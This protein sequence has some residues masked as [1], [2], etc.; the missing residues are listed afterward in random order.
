MRKY[1][2]ENDEPI[3]TEFVTINSQIPEVRSVII[4]KDQIP[5]NLLV[6][7]PPFFIAI[8]NRD[9]EEAKTLAVMEFE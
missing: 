9:E 8:M 3:I 4:P 1:V 2:S 5:P 6:L 7:D